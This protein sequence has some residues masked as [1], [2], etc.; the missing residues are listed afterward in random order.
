[1]TADNKLPF[2]AEIF[3]DEAFMGFL[4]RMSNRNYL[5]GLG[6][7]Y[8]ALGRGNSRRLYV[9]DIPRIAHL[10][11]LSAENLSNRYFTP[12]AD[13]SGLSYRACEQVIRKRYLLRPLQPQLCPLCIAEFGYARMSWDFSLVTACHF[14]R[15]PLIDTCPECAKRITWA[16]SHFAS[17]SCGYCYGKQPI[18]HSDAPSFEL[19]IAAL[20]ASRMNS[21]L[22]I[23][24]ITWCPV[25]RMFSQ[26]SLDSM[27]QVIWAYGVKED[28]PNRAISEKAAPTTQAARAITLRAL[29]RLRSCLSTTEHMINPS[30]NIHIPTLM[31][32]SKSTTDIGDYSCLTQL[33]RKIGQ[34]PPQ[35]R[36]RKVIE[37]DQMELF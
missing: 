5:N 1:M 9:A 14:H 23:S 2:Q 26:M 13:A 34:S 6:W 4:L 32:L 7:L 25:T 24:S 16:R 11:D 33:L 37:H 8:R 19:S 18:G 27:F 20:V 28:K 36:H 17:C 30:R 35:K 22:D 21:A 3:P 10:F 29:S 15:C 12:F 31:T